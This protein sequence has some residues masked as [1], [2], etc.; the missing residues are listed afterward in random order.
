MRCRTV[1]LSIFTSLVAAG[2]AAAE[3]SPVGLWR[4]NTAAGTPRAYVRIHAAGEVY[5]GIVERVFPGPDETEDKVCSLCTDT[6]HNQ[7][8]LGMKILE[9]VRKQHDVYG[10]GT[11]LDPDNG[12]VYRVKLTPSADG[13]T[14][15]LRGYIGIPLFG[16][17]EQ[18]TRIE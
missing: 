17:T 12:K 1:T 2:A 8:I 6:R 16:R 18:W 14:M 13:R 11:V 3:P 4:Y 5:E 10:G 9:G 15:E 7:R